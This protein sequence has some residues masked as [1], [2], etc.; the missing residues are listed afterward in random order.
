M[1]MSIKGSMQSHFSF[2]KMKLSLCSFNVRGLGQKINRAQILP[3]FILNN[4]ISVFYK[5]RILQKMLKQPDKQTDYDFVY[6]IEI[7][8]GK[9][10]ALKVKMYER[11]VDFY[12]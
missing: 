1:S 5:K 4:L 2:G 8:P 11:I 6:H 9:I 10:Q 3:T 7:I 12:K